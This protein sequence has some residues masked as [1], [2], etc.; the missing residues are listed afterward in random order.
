MLVKLKR[1]IIFMT[2]SSCFVEWALSETSAESKITSAM[3]VIEKLCPSKGSLKEEDLGNGNYRISE[4]GNNSDASSL[5]LS[6]DMVLPLLERVRKEMNANSVGAN[7]SRL[8]CLQPWADILV[9]LAFK[10]GVQPPVPAV[11]P[12]A[13]ERDWRS[14]P[15]F[16]TSVDSNEEYWCFT[17]DHGWVFLTESV[18]FNI[19][20][21]SRNENAYKIA[22]VA[23]TRICVLLISRPTVG[24]S[25]A[26]IGGYL[27]AKEK[28]T[29][30]QP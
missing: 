7:Q 22:E 12:A 20:Q 8:A 27:Q 2:L 19:T 9:S 24:G 11:T 30:S 1:L 17:P 5:N 26:A 4:G 14:P 25:R 29:F 21:N 13:T 15:L 16:I 3:L 23:P 18:T 10:K 6:S 28:Q